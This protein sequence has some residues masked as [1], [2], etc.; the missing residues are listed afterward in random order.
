MRPSLATLSLLLFLNNDTYD[1]LSD[2]LYRI[3][4]F[5]TVIGVIGAWIG[6]GFLYHQVKAAN[7]TAEGVTLA[8]RAW[9][10]VTIKEESQGNAGF[11][12]VVLTNHG[13]TPAR[14]IEAVGET[15]IIK[16]SNKLQQTAHR[17]IL[18]GIKL[19]APQEAW[20][21]LTF[22]ANVELAIPGEES[23]EFFFGRAAYRTLFDKETATPHY[24]R[25]CYRLMAN[26]VWQVGG[27]SSY[28]DYT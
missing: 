6:I 16:K 20:T 22:A 13:R 8:E 1:P 17:N 4:L 5:A 15:L 27:A 7:K 12:D 24:T 9:V 28:N 25:F 21:I 23:I 10:L 3:Y 14:I 18:P 2:R 26:G 19:L 11:Y